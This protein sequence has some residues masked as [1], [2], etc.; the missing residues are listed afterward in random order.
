MENLCSG[1]IKQIQAHKLS[2]LS[3]ITYFKSE[4]RLTVELLAWLKAQEMYP[5]FYL[6]YRDEP[7]TIASLG[8]VR[9]FSDEKMAQQFV[10]QQDLPLVGGLTFSKQAKFWLP[11]LLLENVDNILHVTIYFDNQQDFA[12]EQHACLQAAK[13]LEKFTALQS[14]KQ[15]VHKI[16]QKANTEVWTNWI[17]QGLAEIKQGHLSKVVLANQTEFLSD[18]PIDA[19]DFLAESEQQ[20]TGCYHFLLAEQ[21]ECAFVGSTPERLYTRQGQHIQTEALAGTA[22]ITDNPQY[23]QQQTDWLLNDRKNDHEN[24][25]VVQGICENLQ[26]YVNHI[27][28]C[29]VEVKQLRQVQHLRRCIQAELKNNVA[30]GVCL[31]TIHPSAAVSGLPQ[32]SAVQFLQKTENFDRSWYAGTLGIMRKLQAEFCVAIRSAFIEQQGEQSKIRIF[33]GAGIVEGSVPLLEWK[34]I[35]RKAS[36]LL[37]LLTIE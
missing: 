5:Q 3:T 30:D 17:E 15:V 27:A 31:Q 36:S 35:E 8:K 7:I 2:A 32:Q 37:S 16:G 4:M 14:V 1:L 21:A 23:N 29:D 19:K 22:T 24:R 10:Q 20:N 9:L 34:E 11:R 28:V 26:P 18:Q 12:T 6:N 25:L 13:T 33:A